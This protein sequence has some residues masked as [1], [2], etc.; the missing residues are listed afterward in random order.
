MLL[1][2]TLRQCRTKLNQ[3]ETAFKML[4]FKLSIK[5]NEIA[6][7]TSILSIGS[8]W[9]WKY[10]FVIPINYVMVITDVIKDQVLNI[11]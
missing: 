1:C 7:E 6:D 3:P 2:E 10:L 4:S 8:V 5:L 9:K 11:T